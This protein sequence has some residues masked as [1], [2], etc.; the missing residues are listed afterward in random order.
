M[1][2]DQLRP[3]GHRILVK[4]DTIDRTKGGLL[5]PDSA[6][7]ESRRGVVISHGTAS[8]EFNTKLGDHVLLPEYGGDKYEING[9]K[10][11]MIEEDDILAILED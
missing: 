11:I 8:E 10:H 3:N 2:A 4:M 9:S 5:I 1:R 7:P 6:L